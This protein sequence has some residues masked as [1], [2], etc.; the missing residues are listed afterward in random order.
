[1][2]T[3][4]TAAPRPAFSQPSLTSNGTLLRRL[5][6]GGDPIE[7]ARLLQQQDFAAALSRASEA[8]PTGDSPAARAAR[9]KEA[10]EEFVSTAFVMPLLKQLRSGGVMGQLPPPFGPGPG[11]K[12]FRQLADTQVSR[13]IVRGSNWPLVDTITHSLT[14]PRTADPMAAAQPQPGS[15]AHQRAINAAR[16]AADPITHAPAQRPGGGE[17]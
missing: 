13:G 4:A 1:M 16:T 9:A 10:A 17:P 14:R 15:P 3:P 2:N 8:A 5:D 12:Q 7:Q 6:A 11:E